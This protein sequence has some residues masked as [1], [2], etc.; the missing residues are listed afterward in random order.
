MKE[1]S[2]L[3]GRCLAM[4]ATDGRAYV[5]LGKLLAQQRRTEE[6]RAVYE[7]GSTATGG[8]N[9]YIWQ[10]W[11]TLEARAGNASHARKVRSTVAACPLPLG[12]V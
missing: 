3:L 7:E 1:P 6:A 11:A 9:E 8:R 4:D 2:R 12:W 10:A 5:A